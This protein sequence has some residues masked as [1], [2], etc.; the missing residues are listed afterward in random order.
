MSESEGELR[1]QL[2]RARAADELAKGD[3]PRRPRLRTCPCCRIELHV[4][5]QGTCANCG[6][7]ADPPRGILEDRVERKL[8]GEWPIHR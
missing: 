5:A 1:D 2:T 4:T 3:T 7:V 6:A 8:D